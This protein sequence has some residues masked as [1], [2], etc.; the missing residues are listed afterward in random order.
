MNSKTKTCQ[1]CKKGF[2]IEPED[3][4]FY[5]KI[6]VPAPTFC[7]ECRNQ[8]RMSFR[9]ERS[10]YKRKCDLCGMDIVSRY[11]PSPP[12]SWK[13][14]LKVY[15]SKCWWSDKWDALEYAQ[16]YDINKSFFDQFKE[17]IQKTPSPSLFQMGQSVNSDW[18]NY[19]SF[20]KNCYLNV[21]GGYNEDSAYNTYLAWGNNSFDNYFTLKSNLC[22]ETIFSKNCYKVFF[23]QHCYDCQDVILSYDC[24]NCSN[25]IGCIGLRHKKYYIFNKPYSKKEYF[26]FLDKNPISSYKSLNLIKKE[27]K[28]NILK[29]PH[30][31]TVLSK[32][33]DCFGNYITQSKNCQNCWEIE[34]VENSKYVY[35]AAIGIKD[36]YDIY[37]VGE[38]SEL[39]YEIM[40]GGRFCYRDK[41]SISLTQCRDLDYC[42]E[43]QDCHDCF[44]CRGLIKKSYCILN[45]QYSLESYTKLKSKIIKKMK[46]DK[47]YGEFFPISLSP[48]GYNESVAQDYY[49][50]NKTQS[51]K[52]GANWN[53]YESKEKYQFS[54]YQIPDNINDVKDDIL[55]KILKCEKSNKAYKIIPM[56][57]KF[58]RQMGLPI[59]KRSPLQRYRDRLSQK[60][61]WK[62]YYRQCM[63]AGDTDDT[64]TYKNTI[65]HEHK[66]KHCP[67]E[68][69]TSYAPDRK[70]IVY[71]EKCY[72]KEVQ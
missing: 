55:K 52:I 51:L 33:I 16:E 11:S 37:A 19:E 2:T 3:F 29:F 14:S 21:G 71:C 1:S 10:L 35:I 36:V 13:N 17:I 53:D 47:E 69:Q 5:E 25:L 23:S 56:E 12:S 70:E 46:E 48:F 6:G 27:A 22:Y 28:K 59:P 54:D 40:S 44:G 50:L 64:K 62:L 66:D 20:D 42:L 39:I 7:S 34:D 15:C 63:C 30:R 58:Y 31:Y 32:S 8:R 18:V 4:E 38:N 65:K 72:Q 68:F 60:N 41:F 24:K 67:N 9:N 26:D 57:L 43:M 49:P 45:K 61:P